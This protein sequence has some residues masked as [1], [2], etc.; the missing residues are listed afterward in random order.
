M[1]FRSLYSRAFPRKRLQTDLKT[2]LPCHEDDRSAMH[3]LGIIQITEGFKQIFWSAGDTN[4]VGSTEIN[5][6]QKVSKS[7]VS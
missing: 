5:G 2:I 6:A 1:C 7:K 4:L 3:E